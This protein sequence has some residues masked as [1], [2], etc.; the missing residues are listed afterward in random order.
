MAASMA[1]WGGENNGA[2]KVYVHFVW[3]ALLLRNA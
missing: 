2:C 3:N 1:N